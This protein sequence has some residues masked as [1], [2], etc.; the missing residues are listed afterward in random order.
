MHRLIAPL[1]ALLVTMPVVVIGQTTAPSPTPVATTATPLPPDF[2]SKADLSPIRLM[3]VQ[4]QQTI[5]TF[6]SYARQTLEVITGHGSYKGEDPTFT[7]LDMAYRPQAYQAENMIRVANLPLRTEFRKL[8]SLSDDEKE[9]IVKTGMVSLQL[10]EQ[11]EVQNLLFT[12]QSADV[13]KA[14]AVQQFVGAFQTMEQLT[15]SLFGGHDLFVPVAVVPPAPGSA[16]SD[17]HRVIDVAGLDPECVAITKVAGLQPPPAAPGYTAEMVHPTVHADISLFRGWLQ[18]DPQL[19]TEAAKALASEVEVIN[20]A[21]YPTLLKR[22]VEVEYNRLAK[23]TLPGAACYFFAFVCFLAAANSGVTSLR[24][25][26]LR[27]LAL[28]LVVHTAGI[29]VRWWLVGSI[30]IKNEF[31]SV[32]FSAWFG[33]LIGFALELGLIQAAVRAVARLGGVKMEPG[34]PIRNLFGSAAGFVGWLSLIAI[35]TVPYVF[36]TNIGQEVG[37]S[38]GVLYSYWLYIHVTMVTASYA[39]IGMAFLLSVWWLVK[40]YANFGTLSRVPGRQ[41]EGDAR[42][43]EVVYPGGGSGGAAAVSFPTLLAQMAFFPVA[44]PAPVA[45]AR[46]KAEVATATASSTQFL[47]ALDACNLVVLQMAFWVLG[48]G[49]ILGAVW[50]DMSWGRPWGWDPKETFALVTWIVYLITVHVR[51]ATEHKAWWTAVMATFGFFVMLFNWVG[52]N[53]FFHGLHSYA[54]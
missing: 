50:A 35:F 26:G 54:G 1:F 48:T 36:G 13:R 51:V 52:V 41:L 31:E 7:V 30:P 6:D 37:R 29:G 22:E 16:S 25:W 15:N 46:T 2:E 5:K 18:G 4:H 44:K 24:L 11:P 33:V 53:Y 3:A 12:A 45:V 49:I 42:G 14:Q 20:P 34:S 43:F 21:A 39:L 23:M 17:W 19:V 32:M 47:A 27:L 38:N 10:V 9:R 28:G 40:Y 8:P